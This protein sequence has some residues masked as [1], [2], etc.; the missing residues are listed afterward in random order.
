MARTLPGQ[1]GREEGEEGTEGGKEVNLME[2]RGGWIWTL[3]CVT[4]LC[5]KQNELV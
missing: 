2:G 3:L 5:L 4:L 1:G